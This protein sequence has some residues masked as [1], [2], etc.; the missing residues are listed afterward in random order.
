[1]QNMKHREVNRNA[2]G[3]H[4]RLDDSIVCYCVACDFGDC[5]R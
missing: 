2:A 5:G 4:E 1:M 3:W